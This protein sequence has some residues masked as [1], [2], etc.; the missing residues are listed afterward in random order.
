MR[1]WRA[2]LAVLMLLGVWIA[3]AHAQRSLAAAMADHA[4]GNRAAVKVVETGDVPAAA[5]VSVE[6]A[7]QAMFRSAEVVFAGEVTGVERGDG[8]VAV[9]F[10]VEEAVRGVAVGEAYMLRE[11]AGLWQDDAARYSVGQRRL[12]LLHAPSAAGFAS[13][14]AGD[15]AVP[16]QGEATVDLRWIAA[17][18]VSANAAQLAPVRA[19]QAAGGSIDRASALQA[20][21][22]MVTTP[23][24]VE[25][26]AAGGV[27]LDAHAAVD[28]VVVMDLLHAWQ[29]DAQVAR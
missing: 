29:R 5:P 19:L 18:V 1:R 10:R 3:S 8:V 16:L 27:A 25:A 17:R 2:G 11:W 14:V 12:M 23:L 21:A 13:P 6:D 22:A 24:P 28:R 9:R 20:R 26:A 15:G 7:L 4:A